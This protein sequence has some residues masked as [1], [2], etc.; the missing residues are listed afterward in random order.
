LPQKL[1]LTFRPPH[2]VKTDKERMHV[3][4][5]FPHEIAKEFAAFLSLVTRRRIF[6]G[7]QLRYGGLP[8]EQ[9]GDIYQRSH[10]Q[11][12]QR[13]KEINP[14]EIYGLME[15]LQVMDRH[16]A[17]GFILAMRLYHSAVEMMY[18]D[19]E[20]SY[21]FLIMCLETISSVVFQDYKPDSEEEFLDS[22]YSGWKILSN[23]L[24][25][26]KRPELKNLLLRNEYF[27][28]QKLLRFV[29]ENIPDS[30]WSDKE[31][32]AK[33]KYLS[34]VVEAGPHGQGRPYISESN[35]KI[36]E[37]EKIEKE[38][39]RQVLRKI[40]EARSNLI[41]RGIRLPA[42]IVIGHFSKIP[43]EAFDETMTTSID[44]S[45]RL[46][47]IPP[48]ITLERLVS[49]SMVEFL[50]KQQNSVAPERTGS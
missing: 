43:V 48:L 17:E 11:E 31:D 33:P 34:I 28:I 21:L 27:T 8:I 20:F 9:E 26:E 15:T 6:P 25:P 14:E 4:G 37:W 23:S 5:I 13:L 10:F 50:R 22:R 42:S 29:E 40:Y 2:E 45:K 32:D 30:F 46:L 12:R 49:Y 35:L 1:V 18:T 36:Q 41:H 47:Q 44:R 16:L 19:P 38:S 7:G 39:L 24:P 3:S